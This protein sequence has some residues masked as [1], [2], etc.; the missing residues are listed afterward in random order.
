MLVNEFPYICPIHTELTMN[1]LHL[2]QEAV[3][4]A[5]AVSYN[6]GLALEVHVPTLDAIDSQF[7]QPKDRLRETLKAW[8]SKN[9]EHT[10][11]AIVNALKSH[12]V[13][14]P[15]LAKD[16]EDKHCNAP[17]AEQAKMSEA[18]QLQQATESVRTLHKALRDSQKKNEKLTH[19]VEEKQ[20]TIEQLTRDIERHQKPIAE[21]Q[22]ANHDLRQELQQAQAEVEE[23]QHAHKCSR[24]QVQEL[25]ELQQTTTKVQQPPMKQNTIQ[26]MKWDK[27][28][29]AP[30]KMFRGSAA[31]Y[32]NRAY[33]NGRG[34][35]KIHSYNSDTQKWDELHIPDTPH[36]QHTL[37]MVK[38][39]LTIV[40][41][42]S[43]GEATNSIL[44]L[45]W[46][47]KNKK[48]IWTSEFREM[49]SKRMNVAAICSG[50]SLIVAGGYDGAQIL[51]VVEVLNTESDVSTQK[52]STASPLP[53]PYG[54]AT[55]SI[56]G[57]SLF[58]LGGYDK[59][60]QPTRLVL[61]CS[62]SKLIE[63]CQPHSPG[64]GTI[65]HRVVDS[66]F[67]FSSCATLRD[68]LV[69]VGGFDDIANA[70]TADIR[71]YNICT[72]TPLLFFCQPCT[73]TYS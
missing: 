72:L 48:F 51:T 53:Y 60:E 73:C 39:L 56:C 33:F 37:V 29:T 23:K 69:L 28:S 61:T 19:Q 14:Y 21:P 1:D 68:E 41:G 17:E 25:D 4:D 10:W 65:W 52:W 58:M 26:D 20:S 3:F 13:G 5:R 34:S 67:Y 24:R 63:S 70:E 31:S 44:S 45:T 46:D 22:A 40:G 8:L 55:A 59:P 35:T 54:S 49:P 27:E 16:I 71:A 38:D 7:V 18:Q 43:K 9:T 36:I 57:E 66:P 30:E 2:I 50:H 6:I 32:L 15:K 11:Q 42:C 64:V 47:E 12:V 62:I